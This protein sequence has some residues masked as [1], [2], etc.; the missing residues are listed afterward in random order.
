MFIVYGINFNRRVAF[1]LGA[2]LRHREYYIY[3]FFRMFAYVRLVS[4]FR[5]YFQIY[6]FFDI[7]KS[8]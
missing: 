6:E 5:D 8:Y 4:T 2:L 3:L 7:S 1:R